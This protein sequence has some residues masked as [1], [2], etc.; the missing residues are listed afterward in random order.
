MGEKR[1]AREKGK[2]W[3]RKGNRGKDAK[4]IDGC[5]TNLQPCFNNIR[6]VYEYI[7]KIYCYLYV[8]IIDR[9][10]F[11]FVSTSWERKWIA[12]RSTRITQ[13]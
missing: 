10:K 5:R 4:E 7:F 1:K 12:C 6:H 8:I 9:A 3:E 13:I 2:E 11:A